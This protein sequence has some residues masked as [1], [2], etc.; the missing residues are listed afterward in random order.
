[1]VWR[2]GWLPVGTGVDDPGA[3]DARGRGTNGAGRSADGGT[4][5]PVVRS[6]GRLDGPRA[7][8]AAR[9]VPGAGDLGAAR[10]SL[11]PIVRGLSSRPART[12]G[13]RAIFGVAAPGRA[14]L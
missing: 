4:G 2:R 12:I 8:G 5:Q 10:I 6:P 13:P 7:I 3:G 9:R 11:S 1:M 14:V